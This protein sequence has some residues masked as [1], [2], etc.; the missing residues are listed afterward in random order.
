[1]KSQ[2]QRFET[3]QWSVVLAA[4]LENTAISRDALNQLCHRYW[5]PVYSFVRRTVSDGHQAEDITQAFFSAL[6]ERNQ[7]KIVEPDRGRFRNFMMAAVTNFI[8]NHFRAAGA[9]KRGGNREHFQLS[10]ELDFERG[11]QQFESI[12]Q[13]LEADQ[14]FDRQWALVVL[15]QAMVDLKQDYEKAGRREL[16]QQLKHLI[17]ISDDDPS[18]RTIANNIGSNENQIKV[19]AHRLRVAF[20]EKIREIIA[21]TVTSREEVEDEIRCFFQLFS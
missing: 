8:N 1:M 3:T 19:S 5:F 14:I 4:G 7:F 13:S 12:N 11:D 15:R 17:S 6:I 20:A 2:P 18:Y 21:E 9:L 10:F 16:F